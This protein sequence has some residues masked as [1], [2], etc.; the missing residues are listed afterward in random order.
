MLLTINNKEPSPDLEQHLKNFSSQGQ[1]SARILRLLDGNPFSIL[2]VPA[3]ISGMGYD[4]HSADTEISAL[5]HGLSVNH[6]VIEE[7]KSQIEQRIGEVMALPSDDARL[8]YT[9]SRGNRYTE[10]LFALARTHS[11]WGYNLIKA[12]AYSRARNP[13]FTNEVP[14]CESRLMSELAA[15]FGGYRREH[16][17]EVFD[18]TKLMDEK[19]CAC[20]GL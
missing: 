12:A 10:S 14:P 13:V 8:K 3:G 15:I 7:L 5:F 17:D 20:L 19:N 9:E 16:P 1:L 18:Y 4:F 2:E 6:P 11:E